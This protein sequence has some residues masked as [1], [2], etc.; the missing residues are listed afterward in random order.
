MARAIPLDEL[1]VYSRSN[2]PDPDYNYAS[3]AVFLVDKPREWSSFDVVKHLRKCVDLRKVGHAGTL[4]P[5]AT[6]LLV[7]CCGKATKTISEI[8]ERPKEYVGEV[9]FG[10]A[11]PSHDAETE[12][13]ETASYDHITEEQVEKVLENKF[14]GLITQVPPM[15]SALKH[16]GTPLYKLARKGKKVKRKPRQVNIYES[17]ILGFDSPRLELYV[18]C[19]KGTYIRSLAYDLGKAVGSLAHLTMLNRTAIGSF[20]IEEA[21][22]IEDLDSIF[23]NKE[24]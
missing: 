9:T 16:K 24:E 22:A 19:S 1:P 8:Q 3:G 5:M 4:D 23:L 18:K 10:A 6:G 17:R 14:S 11:T 7:L 15:Y 2:L 21:L 12:V 20:N 13:E